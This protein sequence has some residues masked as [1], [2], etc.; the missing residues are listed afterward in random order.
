MAKRANKPV[1]RD[2]QW[3][4]GDVMNVLCNPF[5]VYSGTISADQWVQAMLRLAE[6]QGLESTLRRIAAIYDEATGAKGAV[7]ESIAEQL[8]KRFAD[9]ADLLSREALFRQAL[10]NL[11]PAR[12]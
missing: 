9:E 2:D 4:E 11:D 6:E 3:S 1:P 5:H 12:R 7:E 8:Q 10:D